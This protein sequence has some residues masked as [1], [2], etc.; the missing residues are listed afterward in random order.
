MKIT[1]VKFKNIRG[2]SATPKAVDLSCSEK[3]P[4]EGLELSD[5]HLEYAGGGPVLKTVA[6][7]KNVK[8]Q[9]VDCSFV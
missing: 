3:H 6:S 9:P 4:C 8:G 1:G 5:I 7:C 2:T